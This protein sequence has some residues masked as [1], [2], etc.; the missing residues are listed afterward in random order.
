MFRLPAITFSILIAAL[1]L[2]GCDNNPHPAPLRKTR[3]DGAPWVVR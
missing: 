1:L 3:T 2:C